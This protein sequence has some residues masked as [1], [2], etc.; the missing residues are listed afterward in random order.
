MSE[1]FIVN[2]CSPTLAGIKTGS[3]FPCPG[4]SWDSMTAFS[5]AM[6]R[7]LSG[8]GLFCLPLKKSGGQTLLYLC[9]P[10]MLWRDLAQPEAKA[11]LRE[12]H[13]PVESP[14]KCLSHL[15][16]VLQESGEFPH[17][18]GLF[19]GYPPEDVEGFIRNQGKKAKRVG[20]WKV[21]GNEAAAQQRFLAYQT[22]RRVY[23]EHY[24]NGKGIDW[25]AVS[26][27]E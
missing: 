15:C 9:R 19:L 13:Y 18:I 8:K 4:E 22:C 25:L 3:L 6:N 10:Q 21:Y 14:R 16:R 23:W 5:R 2:N 24:K 7:R 17:E 12:K 1:E 11:I 20:T 27:S 26:C